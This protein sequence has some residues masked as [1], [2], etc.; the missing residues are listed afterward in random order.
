MC[1]VRPILF[2]TDMVRAILDGRK[3]STRRLIKY[4]FHDVYGY[5]CFH[6]MWHEGRG[7]VLT[8][9]MIEGYARAR[10]MPYQPGD[11]LYV[12]ETWMPL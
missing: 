8:P 9:E 2:N 6:G 11:I 7:N 5:A 4:D 10:E 12:R 3:T 1:R